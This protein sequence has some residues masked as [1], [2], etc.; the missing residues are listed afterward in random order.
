MDVQETQAEPLHDDDDG[1]TVVEVAGG[2]SHAV[3]Q[4][5]GDTGDAVVV[6]VVKVDVAVDNGK[7]DVDSNAVVVQYGE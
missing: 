5:G 7:L 3:V 2:G 1:D 4:L 6:V